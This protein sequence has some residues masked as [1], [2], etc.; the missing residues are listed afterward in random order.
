VEGTLSL[1]GEGLRGKGV[2]VRVTPAD[3]AMQVKGYVDQLEQVLINLVVNARD[4]LLSKQE[5][6]PAFRPWIAVHCEHDS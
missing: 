1:L 6:D 2:E 4:A 5:K 3:A